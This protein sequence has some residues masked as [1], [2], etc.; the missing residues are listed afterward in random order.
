MTPNTPSVPSAGAVSE[1]EPAVPLKM[2]VHPTKGEVIVSN[3]GNSYT[4]GDKIGEGHFGV[5]FSC[6]DVWDNE[7]AAKVLKPL[8]TYEAVKSRATA[9]FLKLLQVRN[10]FITFVHDAFE[11]RD[12]FYIITERCHGPI[13][14][15]FSVEELSGPLWLKPIARCLLQAVHY[16]HLSGFVH[17]DIHPGNVFAAFIKDELGNTTSPS[18]QFKL[19]DLGVAK[20]FGELNERNTRAVWMIPPEVLNPSEFGPIDHKVD[21]YHVGLLLLQIASSREIRFTSEEVLEGKPRELALRLPPPLNFALE[22]ALRRHTPFRTA[23]AMELWRDLNSAPELPNPT[24][25]A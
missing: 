5:V 6:T 1:G 11:F 25:A 14:T 20:V 21:I 22:K 13:S 23:T 3:L 18:L 15:L 17:Q 4:I 9:E 7:L 16:L 19:A 2:V 12:T 24:I 10:P 8:G